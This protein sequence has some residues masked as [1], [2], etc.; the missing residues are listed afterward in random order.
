MTLAVDHHVAEVASTLGLLIV[1]IKSIPAASRS[2]Q[3]GTHMRHL[4][5]HNHKYKN[6]NKNIS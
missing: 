1:D 6:K 4:H 3:Q 2:L 5:P